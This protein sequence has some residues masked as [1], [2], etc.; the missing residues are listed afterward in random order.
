[1]VDVYVFD[2][3]SICF[4]GK[5]IL[6]KFTLHR[7]KANNLSMKQM[8][9]TSEKLTAEQ[10]DEICGVNTINWDDSSRKHLS[11]IGD[12]EVISHAKVYVFSNL[13]YVLER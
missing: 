9:D 2:I 12:E 4:H 11:L 10:S 7:T 6:R 3:T 5:R 13:C 1:M 8:F